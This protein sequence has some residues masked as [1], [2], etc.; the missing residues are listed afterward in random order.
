MRQEFLIYLLEISRQYSISRPLHLFNLACIS[1][2][3]NFIVL[4]RTK[5]YWS[6]V[7]VSRILIELSSKN[8]WLWFAKY[9]SMRLVGRALLSTC[10]AFRKTWNNLFYIIFFF[11]YKTHRV[12]FF[13]TNRFQ[14]S[15]NLKYLSYIPISRCVKLSNRMLKVFFTFFATFCDRSLAKCLNYTLRAVLA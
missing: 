14:G 10:S 2:F 12:S 6:L 3:T 4:P 7:F 9:Y 5:K 15:S 13:S 8:V 11:C 1:S